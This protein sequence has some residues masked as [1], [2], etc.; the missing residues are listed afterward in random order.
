MNHKPPIVSQVENFR[1]LLSNENIVTRLISY[2]VPEWQKSKCVNSLLTLT[3]FLCVCVCGF[4]SGFSRAVFISRPHLPQPLS[5]F[6]GRFT[7]ECQRTSDSTFTRRPVLCGRLELKKVEDRRQEKKQEKS[8]RRQVWR[9]KWSIKCVQII[10]FLPCLLPL[11]A[12][13]VARCWAEQSRSL[14]FLEIW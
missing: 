9:C 6:F 2:V 4:S 11:I 12:Y 5:V 3:E 1:I 13:C 8:Q 10:L 14:G 7:S